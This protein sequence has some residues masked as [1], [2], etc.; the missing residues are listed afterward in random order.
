MTTQQLR[1]TEPGPIVKRLC[2]AIVLTL[3]AASGLRASDELPAKRLTIHDAVHFLQR[4]GIGA[5]PVSVRYLVG[6]SRSAAIDWLI[7][8]FST[9]PVLDMPGWVDATAP[10][11]WARGDMAREQRRRFNQARDREVEEFRR[12]WIAEMIR[13]DSPQTERMVLL[14]HNHF[15][16]AYSAIDNESTSIAR[17]NRL[18]RAHALGN[19]R[20]FLKSVLRDPAMLNY[21]DNRSNRKHSPNENLARE[22]LELF[23]LGEGN[24]DESTVKEAARALTGWTVSPINDMQF[25]VHPW[26]Q[27]AGDKSLFGQRGAF[28]G[29]DLIDIILQQPQAAQFAA[30]L[31]WRNYISEFRQDDAAITAIADQFRS[32][33][34]ELSVLLRATLSHDAFWHAQYRGG[35]IKSPVDLLLGTVRSTAYVPESW[36]MIPALLGQLG[37][38]L[39][40]PPN[41]AGWA[42]GASWVTPAHLL[43]RQHVVSRL[44]L[45]TTPPMMEEATMAMVQPEKSMP[46]AMMDNSVDNNLRRIHVRLASEDLDGPPVVQLSALNN[47]A[48]IWRSDS[49]ELAAGHDTRMMSRVGQAESLP[50]R[51]YQFELPS[52]T[53]TFDA[54]AVHFL[55][56]HASGAADRNLYV[57]DVAI[58]GIEYSSMSGQQISGCPPKNPELAGALYCAGQVIIPIEAAS[59]NQQE[60]TPGLAI[61]QTYLWWM[62]KSGGD[63]NKKMRHLVLGLLDVESADR[64]IDSMPLEVVH[65][66]DYG[67]AL[68]FS[69]DHCPDCLLGWPACA[70]R[71]EATGTRTVVF[72]FQKQQKNNDLDCHWEALHEEDQRMI[73]SLFVHLPELISQASGGERVLKRPV[74]YADWR[75]KL[76]IA[77]TQLNASYRE[78]AFTPLSFG[79]KEHTNRHPVSRFT[80]ELVAG[81]EP[82]EAQRIYSLLQNEVIE[83]SEPPLLLSIPA[84]NGQT[85]H[86][87]ESVFADPAFQLK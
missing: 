81:T 40:E 73:G 30:R 55:N 69:S 41:V 57:A 84:V 19:Y 1:S 33:D 38:Q 78:F 60:P 23:T 16:S 32:S 47:G 76:G 72:P 34:Y 36:E 4:T 63:D 53:G 2:A 14:W 26:H 80:P 74:V 54:V 70:W 7:A 17:Q 24:Y 45:K 31:F 67:F 27:D 85:S 86:A 20:R 18:F 35:I 48:E 71:N 75:R 83:E 10:P 64:R 37:Q 77:L 6:K 13:T 28:D 44:F 62:Q 58:N 22:L 21:L 43:N 66:R 52:D 15:V 46:A 9:Q 50:W 3:F 42:G 29:D 79:G 61:G 12:W 65:H 8:G 56:D 59:V 5:D 51:T 25:I 49:R 39:L 87:I 11:Y 68:K 82:A